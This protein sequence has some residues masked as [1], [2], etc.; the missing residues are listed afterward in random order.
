MQ[1]KRLFDLWLHKNLEDKDLKLE[2]ESMK[3]DSEKIKESFYK[4]LE[5]G[6]GGLRGVL[7][8]GTN[9]MNIYT[10]R[11]A[12]QGFANYLNK[13]FQGQV[14]SVAIAY[15]SRN[16]SDLFA[17]ECA[18]VMAANGIK[19][20]LYSELMPTP[21]LSFAVRHL[22]CVGGIMITASHNPAKYNGYKAYDEHGCQLTD[23]PAAQVIEEV[24]KVDI[25]DG[26]QTIPFEEGLTQ[27][28]ICFISEEVIQAYYKA[29]LNTRVQ[30]N[31][32]A[33][34]KLK[35]VYTPLN[36]A[37]YKPVC[38]ILKTIGVA[39]LTLVKE[40]LEPNGDFPTCPYP[41]PE[42]KE[43]MELA[44]QKA[45]EESA[46]II[47]ATDPDSDRAGFG[48]VE[49]R[50]YRLLTGNE[51]GVM[52]LDYLLQQKEKANALL[53]KS[54]V[55]KTIVSSKLIDKMCNK[56][57]LECV[58]VLTG[59]K[60]I[61]QQILEL[62][63][64]EQENR[65]LFGYEESFGYLCG[66]YVRDKDAVQ[67]CMLLTQMAADY[68]EKGLSVADRLEEI[69]KI[70][71]YLLNQTDSFTF[72][73]LSGMEKMGEIMQSLRSNIPKNLAGQKV[74]TIKDYFTRTRLDENG[75]RTPIGLPK[76]NILEFILQ[77]GDSLIIRP[78]GTEPKIKA[79]FSVQGT[80]KQEC[81]EKL[82]DLQ[83]VVKEIM[84]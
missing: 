33:V 45:K 81:Q 59:F 7:G 79:Y 13:Q 40:Q 17:K 5:F 2:L 61:G 70:Y 66:S 72:E 38:E 73:G 65:F 16:K 46:D 8:A 35:V 6:T 19:A 48:I 58:D 84:E 20:Y 80:S 9:R 37:G 76:S 64:K 71:G 60:Y 1:E 24:N 41:N 83:Q 43:A 44:L 34:S 31:K 23:I 52:L 77:S 51:I 57:D 62:E 21:A 27:G 26:V 54:L 78:S 82:L 53:P 75:D 14:K 68:K 39:N 74:T 22:G 11:S 18:R 67:A 29:V 55:V 3:N 63:N 25:F 69:Y 47:L 56:Y 49:K 4:N 10:V 36:G 42:M 50:E 30:E 12:T 32:E 28:N 15:D